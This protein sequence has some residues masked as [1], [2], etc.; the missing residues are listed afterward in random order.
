MRLMEAPS[1]RGER[2]S[3]KTSD[4]IIIYIK[5]NQDRNRI[6]TRGKIARGLRS[7]FSL[8]YTTSNILKE[9]GYLIYTKINKVESQIRL[10]EQG[11]GLFLEISNM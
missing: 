3:P 2:M 9:K 6:L 11:E 1:L 4:R 8:I 7:S 5:N 10:S